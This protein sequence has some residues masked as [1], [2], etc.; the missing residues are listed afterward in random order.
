[1]ARWG[2][3]GAERA[4]AGALAVYALSHA[5]FACS[6]ATFGEALH[7]TFHNEVVTLGLSSS[8]FLT[9]DPVSRRIS[10]V[11]C[12]MQAATSPFVAALMVMQSSAAAGGTPPPSTLPITSHPA[13]WQALLGASSACVAWRLWR[14]PPP[15]SP[16]RPEDRLPL[17]RLEWARN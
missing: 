15:A 16:T 1:M 8:S 2:E 17:L 3:G 5:A 7:V 11:L 10:L 4:D 6:R 9:P 12:A 13:M 14:M